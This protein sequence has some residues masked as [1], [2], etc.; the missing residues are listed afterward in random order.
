MEKM[1]PPGTLPKPVPRS[2]DVAPYDPQEGAS[3][4]IDEV[5]ES[6]KGCLKKRA[7]KTNFKLH[8]I[9]KKSTWLLKTN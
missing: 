2:E 9:L 7:A 1:F 3:L 8:S 6:R 4:A 5:R